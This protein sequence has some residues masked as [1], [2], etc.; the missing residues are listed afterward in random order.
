MR[1]AVT[2]ASGFIGTELISQLVQEKTYEVHAID[3]KV[4]RPFP[5]SC[6]QFG[7]QIK[8]R[9]SFHKVD[10]CDRGALSSTIEGIKPDWVFH[11][12]AESHVDNSIHDPVSCITNNV[13]G[14]AH[15]LDSATK[16]FSS[17]SK[18]GKERFRFLFV[19]TD[20]IYGSL[21]KS[22]MPVSEHYKF[23]T[24]SP[25]SASKAA[26]NHLVEAW[27]KTY[28][29]PIISTQCTNNYGPGQ[30]PEKLIPRMVAKA[31][32]GEALP[33]FGNGKQIRDW[34]HV[35][36]HVAALVALM[37]RGPK[38][39]SFNIGASGELQNLEI[40][41]RI[42]S[43]LDEIVPK[44]TGSY[45]DQITFVGDRPGHDTRYALN[46]QKIHDV[47]GWRPTISLEKGL[48]QTVDWYVRNQSQMLRLAA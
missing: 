18:T 20:E 23:K 24:S 47:I 13:V 7:S 34:I 29:L 16:Y 14:S 30:H 45:L 40:A 38:T 42:C 10:L 28:G 26:G 31:I 8:G 6:F 9:V 32:V 1:I 21:D 48:R 15:L 41:S 3:K 11:L 46:W 27:E 17:M 5:L 39:G 19:S 33:I 12:A 43:L 25:Y 4:D 35:S 36:D 37:K 22:Q 44:R 2:G